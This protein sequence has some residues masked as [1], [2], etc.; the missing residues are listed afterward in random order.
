MIL[1]IYSKKSLV[2]AIMGCSNIIY[3]G[4]N[5]DVLEQ[6]NL[7]EG[8]NLQTLSGFNSVTPIEGLDTAVSH[9]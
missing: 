4:Q 6:L 5:E 3:I 8:I 9:R 7:L 2:G 1:L